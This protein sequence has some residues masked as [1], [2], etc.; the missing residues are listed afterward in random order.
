M[1]TTTIRLS[2]PTKER[3]GRLGSF[4]ESYEDIILRLLDEHD[5][6]IQNRK[7]EK[8]QNPLM[9]QVPALEL[10]LA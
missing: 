4:G 1:A 8:S 7:S 6:H 9:G 5:S 2:D 10:V 3:L